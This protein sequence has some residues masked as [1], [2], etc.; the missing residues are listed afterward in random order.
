MRA[1]P[2]YIKEKADELSIEYSNSLQKKINNMVKNESFKGRQFDGIP[3]TNA[4]M[5]N[6]TNEVV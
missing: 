2:E 5:I 3:L 4:G 1:E 6:R